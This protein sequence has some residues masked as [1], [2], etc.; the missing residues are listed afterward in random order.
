MLFI[1][2][3]FKKIIKYFFKW[4]FSIPIFIVELIFSFLLSKKRYEGRRRFRLVTPLIFKKSV[5]YDF[6]NRKIIFLRVRDDIDAE[7][8]GQIYLNNDYGLSKL[9]RYEDLVTIY[10]SIF[11]KN[12][13]PLII[14]CGANN[15]M[16]V[17]YFMETFPCSYVVGV[18]P[19]IHNYLIANSNIIH[20]RG[21]LLNGAIGSKQGKANIVNSQSDHWGFKVERSDAGNVEFYT[22]NNLLFRFRGLKPFIIKID[23]EG[24]EKEL[25]SDNVDWIDLFPLIIIELHDWMLPGNANSKNFLREISK[26]NRDFVFYGENVFSIA[27]DY[28]LD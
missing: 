25:F 6:L 8:L 7:V 10:N 11:N 9:S 5:L 26:R 27:N 15:G 28:K 3:S 16:S 22:V 20:E 24:Y 12:K 14:D 19:D 2:V 23:I 18:E 13:K 1:D 17:R 4:I 21:V